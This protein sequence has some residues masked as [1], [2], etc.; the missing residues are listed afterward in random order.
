MRHVAVVVLYCIVELFR[1]MMNAPVF[2]LESFPA[3]TSS[4]LFLETWFL[5]SHPE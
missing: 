1:S 2:S 5:L 3:L 4:F